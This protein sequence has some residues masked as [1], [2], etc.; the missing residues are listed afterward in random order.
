MQNKALL[1]LTVLTTAAITNRRF[2]SPTGGVP[3][4]GG[5]TLGVADADAASGTHAPVVHQG[6][7]IVEA[8]AAIAKGA[9]IETTNNGRAATKDTGK[10]VARALQAAGAAGEY[11][12]VTLIPN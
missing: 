1:I 8:S 6:T 9:E 7:A 10:T 4:A 5:N 12:E 3:S 11:I 2:V